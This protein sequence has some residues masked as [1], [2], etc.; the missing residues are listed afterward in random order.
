MAH[1]IRHYVR[2]TEQGEQ[3]PRQVPHE[4]LD[5]RAVRV[6]EESAL[7]LRAGEVIGEAAPDDDS[8]ELT[9]AG[10]D[11]AFGESQESGWATGSDVRHNEY[12][13]GWVQGTGHGVVTVRFETRATGPGI[14]RT[15]T[16]PE[17]FLQIADPLDSLDWN[18]PG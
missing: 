9:A 11:S 8:P 16:L 17:P 13:H 1:P 18:E 4:R 10:L 2:V 3:A 6:E 12:G 7:R 5:R 14:A 15:F